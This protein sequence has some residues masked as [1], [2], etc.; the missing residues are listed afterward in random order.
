[1]LMNGETHIPRIL[2][3]LIVILMAFLA[4][5]SA[6]RESIT[7]DEVPHIGAG[8]SYLQKLDFRLNPEH[9]PLAKVMA[10]AP[11]VM[12]GARAD[13][14]S[15]TWE[16]SNQPIRAYLGEW[17]FGHFVV[18]TWNDPWNI[19]PWARLPMLLLMLAL[20]LGIYY[21]G[22]QLGGPWGGVLSLAAYAGA[23]TMLAFGPL[24][25]TDTAATLF[26]LLAVW[27]FAENWRSVSRASQWR[28]GIALAGALLSKF[29][30]GLLF[31]VF[32]IAAFDRD[33]RRGL[34]RT[35]RGIAIAAGIVYTVYLVLSWNQSAD[36]LPGLGDGAAAAAL[37]RFLM[38][39]MLF[40][41]GMYIFS[42]FASRPVFILG[43]TYPHGVWFYFPVMFVLKSSLAFL[44]LLALAL[45]TAALA[46][47]RGLRVVP[48][49]LHMHWRVLWITMTVF[50]TAC[51]LSRLNIGIRHFMLPMVLSMLFL[52][53]LPR[54]LHA[55]RGAGRPAARPSLYAVT[56]LAFATIGTAVLAY[57]YYFP[58]L[59]SLSLG[60]PAYSLTGDSN[61]DWNQ[62]LPEVQRF[63]TD[64]GIREIGVDTS[65]VVDP[66]VYVKGGRFWNCQAP[67]LDDGGLSW[68]AVSASRIRSCP[69]L[70]KSPYETLAGGSVYIFRLPHD[71]PALSASRELDIRP[72]I[73]RSIQYPRQLPDT[74]KILLAG[75]KRVGKEP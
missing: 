7:A 74:L 68:V 63:T 67:L 65:A 45:A 26:C 4:G 23:P 39:P 75:F 16:F 42:L 60:R 25:L 22:S 2:A 6:L 53:P 61:L 40:L 28:F 10:A 33:W 41:R 37:R 55:L 9:P 38:P 34:R 17:V 50:V 48:K 46:R 72:A 70:L 27:S 54:A 13:Y 58:F 51:L 19:V 64:H 66:A 1:M 44:A 56:A 12:Q 59:N 69:W 20:G 21:W 73:L 57:P 52:S 47:R 14:G 3:V 29:T 8:L 36:F 11:L 18:A 24:V 35:I 30:A 49:E 71:I 43:H 5:G 32:A 62:A 31:P 15:Y